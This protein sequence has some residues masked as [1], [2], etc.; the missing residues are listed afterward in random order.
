M[1]NEEIPNELNAIKFDFSK[2]EFLENDDVIALTAIVNLKKNFRKYPKDFFNKINLEKIYLLKVN[3]EKVSV[4]QSFS[5]KDSNSIYLAYFDSKSLISEVN[6]AI[7]HKI[8][9]KIENITD[10]WLSIIPKDL[11]YNSDSNIYPKKGFIEKTAP[12]SAFEDRS[13]IFEAIMNSYLRSVIDRKISEGD[14]ELEKKVILIEKELEN[15]DN[16]FNKDYWELIKLNIDKPAEAINFPENV[17]SIDLNEIFILHNYYATP[18]SSSKG[19][20]IEHYYPKPKID[21][22]DFSQLS[23]FTNLKKVNFEDLKLKSVPREIKGLEN[24]S[25]LNLMSNQV[26]FSEITGF[27]NLEKLNLS[28]N[29]ISNIEGIEN[30]SKLNKLELNFNEINEIPD[31]LNKLQSLEILDLTG[32]KLS[33][34]SKGISELKN[35][36][37]LNLSI[38]KIN[39]IK[40][41]LDKLINLETLVLSENKIEKIDKELYKLKNL[42]KLDFQRNKINEIPDDLNKL[43]HLETLVILSNNLNDIER[44]KL[45]KLLPKEKIR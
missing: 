41:P 32:N 36:K 17:E 2:K 6:K 31:N 44:D 33:E 22:F 19:L 12:K 7:Y 38:N 25:D 35:L 8:D 14:N 18:K 20:I 16:T 27:K 5:K 39:S 26:D 11:K 1:E 40:E 37:V 9:R 15:I 4:S 3:K 10:E 42:K 43:N 24:I 30:L 34:I 28:D 13:E 45:Y 29:K 21:E 23:K